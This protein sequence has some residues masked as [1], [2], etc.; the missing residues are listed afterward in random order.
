MGRTGYLV[1][2]WLMALSCFAAWRPVLAQSP[3]SSLQSKV[4]VAVARDLQ[5]D[6]DQIQASQLQILAPPAMSLPAGAK[7]HVVSVRAGF[8]PGSWLVRMDCTARSDCLPFH[9]VLRS[10]GSELRDPVGRDPLSAAVQSRNSTA[11]S[12]TGSCAPGAQRRSRA[13]GGGAARH[14][15]AGKGGVSGI[16]RAG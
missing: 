14:A 9:V 8:S 1:V 16:G 13:T 10:T 7:L 4:A 15:I 6:S 12:Q 5:F 3:A 2:L 11:G